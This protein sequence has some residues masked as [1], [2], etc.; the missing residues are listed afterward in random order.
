MEI[1][2]KILKLLFAHIFVYENSITKYKWDF[3]KRGEP[4]RKQY[5]E[6]EYYLDFGEYSERITLADY[7]EFMRIESFITEGE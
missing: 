3:D 6:R 5:T 1:D 4:V 7:N 2:E